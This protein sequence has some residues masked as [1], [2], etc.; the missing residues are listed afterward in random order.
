MRTFSVCWM[1]V[2]FSLTAFS[3][4]AEFKRE[5][6]YLLLEGQ[7][8]LER[9]LIL[10]PVTSEAGKSQLWICDDPDCPEGCNSKDPY[11]GNGLILEES[12][13]LERK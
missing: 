10:T 6:R 4:V 13:K 12:R 3:A 8:P 2:V 5:Q 7:V 1:L 9:V 11:W